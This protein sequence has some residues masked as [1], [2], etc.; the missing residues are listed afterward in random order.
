MHNKLVI[1]L[2]I[3]VFICIKGMA[4]NME[5]FNSNTKF[6]QKKASQGI[7]FYALGNEPFWSLDMDLDKEF[8]FKKLRWPNYY[9][10]C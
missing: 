3:S 1:I 8:Q 10:S 7:D 5:E 6:I 2:F 9:C 4:Q